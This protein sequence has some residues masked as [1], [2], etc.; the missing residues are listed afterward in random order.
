M[1]WRTVCDLAC[2]LPEVLYGRS[3]GTPVL[4]VR[5]SFL[6]RLSDDRRSV[7]VKVG[8]E[9]QA[10]LC[11]AKPRTFTPGGP[12]W[13]GSTVAVRLATVERQEMEEV[14]VSAWRRSAPPSLVAEVDPWLLPP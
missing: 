1:R 14:L 4:C 13:N 11:L 7:L 2:R 6:A 9:E 10:A 3:Y 12:L 5:G 8:T